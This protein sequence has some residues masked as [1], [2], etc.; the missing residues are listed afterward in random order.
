MITGQETENK[1]LAEILKSG[2]VIVT[3]SYLYASWAEQI[4]MHCNF[5][6]DNLHEW[7]ITSNLYQNNKDFQCLKFLIR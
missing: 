4:H 2:T 7:M 6:H 1:W 3:L 5:V